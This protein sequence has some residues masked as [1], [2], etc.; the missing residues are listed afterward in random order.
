MFYH[1]KHSLITLAVFALALVPRV[2]SGRFVTIDEAYHWFERVDSFGRAIAA[3][4]YA[5]TNLIGHPGVTTM[6]LGLLGDALFHWAATLGLLATDDGAASRALIRLPLGCVAALCV[7]LAYP[8][9][10][11]L[12]DDWIALVA[13]LLWATEPFLVAHA[14][15][16]HLDSLLTSFM[17]LSV[18]FLL[19]SGSVGTEERSSRQPYPITMS[20][21]YF[22]VGSAVFAGLAMLTK[23][24]SVALLPLAACIMAAHAW[25][26]AGVAGVRQAFVRF[27]IWS[28]LVVHH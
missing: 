11:R 21:R 5:G 16:L 19:V 13:V 2:F 20:S 18:L 7:A 6:W 12:F 15:L 1:R 14:Q 22:L 3:G 9:L 26:K 10:R 17:T 4:D 8:L 23:S 27:M 28:A 24:P 25:H